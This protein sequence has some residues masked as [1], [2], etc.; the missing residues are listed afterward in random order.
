VYEFECVNDGGGYRIS[1]GDR[2]VLALAFPGH[3][4]RRVALIDLPAGTHSVKVEAFHVV[5]RGILDLQI[6]PL[7]K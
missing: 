3:Q 4:N 1:L 6:T 2:V 7:Q 5:D